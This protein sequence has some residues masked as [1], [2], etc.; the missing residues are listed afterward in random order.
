[1]DEGDRS[2]Y[3]RASKIQWSAVL[4]R[5]PVSLLLVLSLAACST[6]GDDTAKGGDNS[7]TDDACEVTA[8]PL[9]PVD[10][11]ADFYY[12]AALTMQL[13]AAD[14]TA[15]IAVLDS[16][17]AAVAG[18]TTVDAATNI[19]SFTPAAP[20]MPSSAYT[21]TLSWCHGEATISF[22]TSAYGS[23]LTADLA[24]KTY[25]VDPAS[26]QFVAPAGAGAILGGLLSGKVLLGITSQTTTINMIGAL[27]QVTSDLQ[28]TCDRTAEIPPVDFSGSPYFHLA[29]GDVTL[30]IAGTEFQIGMMSM[31]GTFSSDGTSFAGG[32]LSGELDARGL[33]PLVT[34]QLG[35][36]SPDALCDLLLGLDV[37]CEACV[38]DGAVYCLNV[39]IEDI[40]ADETG[41]TI[42]AITE[43]DCNE[44]CALSCDNSECPEAAA[45][46][47]CD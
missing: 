8:S 29:P 22:S 19:A 14:P 23:A 28:D 30:S 3:K 21:L 47:I 43:A 39:L 37:P 12:R 32:T 15:S 5:I 10:G 4:T 7:G 6:T 42:G 35:E 20:L 24:G 46:A 44:T 11:Q 27:S 36:T 1:M 25:A 16:T 13:S 34:E 33:A 38:A 18:T 45:Y 17:G 2:A 40:G 26:G 31:S 41:E 9:S